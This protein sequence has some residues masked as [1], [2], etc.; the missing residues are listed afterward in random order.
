MLSDALNLMDSELTFGTIINN[1]ILRYTEISGSLNMKIA[2]EMANTL[3]NLEHDVLKLN[4]EIYN[5]T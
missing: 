3:L 4:E 1:N 5:H 2:K